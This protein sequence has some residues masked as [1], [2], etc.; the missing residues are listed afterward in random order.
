MFICKLNISDQT[1][2]TDA[3]LYNIQAAQLY[4][5]PLTAGE[6]L[7]IELP[8]LGET[9]GDLL[10]QVYDSRGSLVMHQKT[11]AYALAVGLSLP[12]RSQG[13]YF[14]EVSNE[15]GRYFGKVLVLD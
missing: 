9:S 14:V 13:V 3:G 8:G 4:P 1:V 12:V 6:V 7:H 11:E 10:L 15:E 2:A 5:N